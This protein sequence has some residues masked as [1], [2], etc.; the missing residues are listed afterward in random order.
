MRMSWKGFGLQANIVEE[1]VL[2]SALLHTFVGLMR[3]WDQKLSSGPT[4][5]QLKVAIADLILLR[6]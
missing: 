6:T 4:C 1:Y 2:L 3:T 5:G